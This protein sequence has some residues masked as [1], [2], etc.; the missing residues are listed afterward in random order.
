MGSTCTWQDA[1]ERWLSASYTLPIPDLCMALLLLPLKTLHS[2]FCCCRKRLQI[3]SQFARLQ[4]ML[5]HL[6]LPHCCRRT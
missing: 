4:I 3:W 6:T 1:A 5:S 2:S